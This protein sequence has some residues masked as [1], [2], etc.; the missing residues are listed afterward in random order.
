MSRFLF[1][2]LLCLCHAQLLHPAPPISESQLAHAKMHMM[3]SN[4]QELA[5]RIVYVVVGPESSGNRYLVKF[6]IEAGECLGRSGHNQPF[7]VRT[8]GWG[9]WSYLELYEFDISNHTCAVL[10]RSMPHG[11]E[12]VNLTFIIQQI[13]R[14]GYHPHL[15][16]IHRADP[17]VIQSQIR[18]HH[19][20]SHDQSMLNIDAAWRHIFKAVVKTNVH[21][22]LLTYELLQEQYYIDWL[23]HTLE[24]EHP[25]MAQVPKFVS[26]N[27]KYGP[28]VALPAPSPYSRTQLDYRR[29]YTKSATRIVK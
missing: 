11:G 5:K 29:N 16:M 23:M 26:Q 7:D 4:Q 13:T 10:H 28:L 12:F 22:T 19:T 3:V 8:R 24:F 21:Y 17:V 9:S 25:L 1:I 2:Y 20:V 14:A 18:N 6:M 15:L 27:D